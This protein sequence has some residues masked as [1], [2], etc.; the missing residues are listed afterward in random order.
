LRRALANGGLNAREVGLVA[1]WA[2]GPRARERAEHAVERG[3]GRFAS[4]VG[5]IYDNPRVEAA[6]AAA[7]ARGEVSVAVALTIDPAKG[8]LALAF[9]RPR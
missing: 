7:I 5:R 9:T 2:T 1:V 4:G 6:C 3:L 8:N